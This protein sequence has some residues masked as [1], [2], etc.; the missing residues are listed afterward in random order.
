MSELK[1]LVQR[2]GDSDEEKVY[3]A[4]VALGDLG[5][6]RVVPVL[7]RLLELTSSTRIRNGAAIGLRE[8][9]DPRAL[10]PLVR[11][12]RTPENA[13]GTIIWALET[14]NARSAVIDLARFV[15]EGEYE[16]AWM[17]MVAMQGFAGPQDG[18]DSSEES[19]ILD[20]CLKRGQVEKWRE[21]MLADAIQFLREYG[22]T[23]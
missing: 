19:R 5:D 8:L 1:E 20:D 16:A 14:L 18:N 4:A 13:T 11:Q 10:D 3:R 17:S 9:A 21:E 2:L 22:H 23:Q 12:I 7:I 15:C 6:A